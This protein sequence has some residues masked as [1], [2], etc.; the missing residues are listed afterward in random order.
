M[1]L[2]KS[3]NIISAATRFDE[4][5]EHCKTMAKELQYANTILND[6]KLGI[7]ELNFKIDEEYA[8]YQRKNSQIEDLMRGIQ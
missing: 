6:E 4:M 3:T 7:S 2:K 1:K 5:A 8:R